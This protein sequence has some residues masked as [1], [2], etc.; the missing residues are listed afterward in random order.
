MSDQGW[1]Y[2]AL[3][4]NPSP[5]VD[6]TGTTIDFKLQYPPNDKLPNSVLSVGNPGIPVAANN[7]LSLIIGL[8]L[9][10][11]PAKFDFVWQNLVTPQVQSSITSQLNTQFGAGKYS[12]TVTLPQ[13]GRT[14]A[15]VV[16]G[17]PL[18]IDYWVSGIIV[19]LD[20]NFSGH[21]GTVHVTV[22]A[23]FVVFI[24]LNWPT[25]AIVA[26]SSLFNANINP[27][28][29]LATEYA[30]AEIAYNLWQRQDDPNLG[31]SYHDYVFGGYEYQ[32]DNT[33]LP[34]PDVSLLTVGFQ[35]LG[36]AAA[37]LG[38]LQC[39]PTTNPALPSPLTLTMIHP[40][41]P[42]PAA[43]DP[44]VMAGPNV[45]Y[46]G[47][48][49]L[50]APK[51]ALPGSE[52]ACN[53]SN[54]PPSNIL[55]IAWSDTCSGKVV[56]SVITLDPPAPGSPYR[57]NRTNA[58]QAQPIFTLPAGLTGP[59]QATVT[60]SDGLTQTQPSNQVPLQIAGDVTLVLAYESN[61]HIA[62]PTQP[63]HPMPGPK[64]ANVGTYP[65]AADGTFSGTVIIPPDAVA[66]T[67]ATLEATANGIVTA[68]CQI[69][70]VAK[71]TPVIYL[72][73]PTNLGNYAAQ[74]P[75]VNSGLPVSVRGE[76][77][78]VPSQV[79][80]TINKANEQSLVGLG[81][82]DITR[83]NLDGTFNYPV[84]IW[85]PTNPAGTYTLIAS[86]VES[87]LWSGPTFQGV[88][89]NLTVTGWP[90]LQ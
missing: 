89:A 67:T 59:Y 49:I 83:V 33:P 17:G 29:K 77:F 21:S 57:I 72:T 14:R 18:I 70:I 2:D 68:Q 71:K 1:I 23:E 19:E 38:L 5:V 40:L 16:P 27:T 4:N 48:P 36:A 6:I 44:L 73:D 35:A 87:D 62:G 41:D 3:P 79:A 47:G 26:S 42:A 37:P 58:A 54:F 11:L 60:D 22:D 12:D 69:N 75:V 51:Q 30:A 56:N 46:F 90:A 39:V 86:Q 80:I 74:S 61:G 88:E 15:R 78:P 65:A 13:T 8:V 45:Y 63:P 82:G 85:P 10:T 7:S 66:G 52:I 81:D 9:K 55:R 24:Y 28:G 20:A 50:V 53:G 25:P 43:Y 84:F 32:I 31:P 64:T 76:N 34:V